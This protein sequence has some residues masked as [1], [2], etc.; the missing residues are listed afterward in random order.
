MS[1]KQGCWL[2][3]FVSTALAGT[4]L[5]FWALAQPRQSGPGGPLDGVVT[6]VGLLFGVGLL[7]V[8]VVSFILRPRTAVSELLGPEI[9]SSHL[10]IVAK[11]TRLA[12]P[13]SVRLVGLCHERPSLE[14]RVAAKLTLAETDREALFQNSIFTEGLERPPHYE[15]GSRASW[16]RRGRLQTRVDRV[17]YLETGTYIECSLGIE[18]GQTVLYLSWA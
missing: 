12:F 6:G 3:F 1:L 15:L 8:A 14:S 18:D 5:F 13:A 9:T 7:A 17:Q 11:H 2:L 10:Q 16:W 4:V